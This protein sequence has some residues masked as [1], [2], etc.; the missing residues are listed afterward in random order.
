MNVWGKL[1]HCITQVISLKP[2]IFDYIKTVKILKSLLKDLYRL[3]KEK[4]T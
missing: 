4:S 1:D 3:L 2:D